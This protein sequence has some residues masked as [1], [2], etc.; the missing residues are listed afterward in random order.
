MQFSHCF[1]ALCTSAIIYGGGMS[2]SAK[3]TDSWTMTVGPN[4]TLTQ[5]GVH[6]DCYFTGPK[7][8]TVITGYCNCGPIDDD[9][10]ATM[11]ATYTSPINPEMTFDCMVWVDDPS[12][13]DMGAAASSFDDSTLVNNAQCILLDV[14]STSG[15][16]DYNWTATMIP[17]A[18]VD[19]I[20]D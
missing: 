6:K 14:Q 9:C 4:L 3:A 18:L 16:S 8:G 1:I 10:S 7:Q 11:K 13:G 19:G 15:A 12:I 20:A 5:D 2:S 17:T